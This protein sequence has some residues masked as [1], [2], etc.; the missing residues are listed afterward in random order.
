MRDEE[1]GDPE[2]GSGS[3][4]IQRAQARALMWEMEHNSRPSPKPLYRG[5]HLEPKGFQSWS[6]KKSVATHWAGKNNGKVY[7]VPKGTRGL[8]VEDYTNS[9]FDAEKEWVLKT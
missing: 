8:R 9:A 1:T 5:S 6:E 2:P 3:G 4:K 7:T